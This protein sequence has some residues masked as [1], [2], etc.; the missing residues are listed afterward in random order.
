MLKN[1]HVIEDVEILKFFVN[2]YSSDILSATFKKEM[3]AFQLSE[4]LDIPIATVYRKI[5]SLESVGLLKHVKTIINT[6]G[7]EE[8]YYRCNIDKI[9]A[10]F[11]EG[12]LRMQVV[13]EGLDD[14]YIR[15][16]KKA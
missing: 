13:T 10:K 5:K 12:K 6:S 11:V 7:N 4:E 15:L 2:G 3:S 9:S 8:K 16:W 1:A 14:E